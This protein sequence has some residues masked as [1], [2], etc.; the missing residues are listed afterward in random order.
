MEINPVFDYKEWMNMMKRQTSAV[1]PYDPFTIYG[2][3]TTPIE[4][5][6]NYEDLKKAFENPE[7]PGGSCP[8]QYGIPKGATDLQDLI[9]YREMNFA[10]GNIF[11][12]CYRMGT[13]Q[14]SDRLRELN[15]I[16]WFVKREIDLESK[17]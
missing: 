13:C 12:A 11:K 16:L 5:G 15:K 6:I 14:H 17:K 4:R 3:A 1:R 9:E 8:S 2:P 10:L 7:I